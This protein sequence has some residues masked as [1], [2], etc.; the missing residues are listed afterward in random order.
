MPKSLL[1]LVSAILIAVFLCI[2]DFSLQP[3]KVE[4]QVFKDPL[5]EYSY[6]A[7]IDLTWLKQFAG[8]IFD[9]TGMNPRQAAKIKEILD[10]LDKTGIVEIENIT[11][12]FRM[13]KDRFTGST[14]ITITP[15][16]Q[17]ADLLHE[18]IA[19]PPRASVVRAMIP[20]DQTLAWISV[21]D[22]IP[23][24]NMLDE[25]IIQPIQTKKSNPL[26]ECPCADL[27][28]KCQ[29]YI[30]D[31][32]HLVFFNLGGFEDINPKPYAALII[33]MADGIKDEDIKIIKDTFT[34]LFVDKLGGKMETG[35]WKER[36]EVLS[37]KDFGCPLDINPSLIVDKNYLIFATHPETLYEAAGYVLTPARTA[38][39]MMP[40]VMNAMVSVNID[41]LVN[42]LPP[43]AWQALIEMGIGSDM[44][45]IA[46]AVKEED[47]GSLQ[48]MRTHI[49]DGVLID[50]SMDR[51]LFSL[52]FTIWQEVMSSGIRHPLLI[53][54]DL[55][56]EVKSNLHSIHTAIERYAV[57]NNGKY[58]ET[59]K[60]LI[61]LR[62]LS[63]F[64]LNPYT[65]EQMKDVAFGERAPGE[66]TYVPVKN[67]ES[68]VID[69]FYLI[70]YGESENNYDKLNNEALIKNNVVE[71]NPDGVPDDVLLIVTGSSRMED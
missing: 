58:P 13:E 5:L 54:S 14:K 24:F 2:I 4:A 56:S 71:E 21:M 66:F 65:N 70:G 49:P 59:S 57:D 43:D 69:G 18:V 68:K 27:F 39:A 40:V 22:P 55:E 44:S 60:E 30:G 29:G 25:Y 67:P 1:R 31:E 7:K 38:Q 48:L 42:I 35:N 50:C 12:D 9:T 6:H 34:G 63:K 47:W 36:F 61:E 16:A 23:V 33:Q 10:I 11:M 45:N 41:K 62:Y 3:S 8:K 46:S 52:L 26:K 32:A 64:P 19:I 28:T 37:F 20:E 51:S 53:S 15:N 17:R